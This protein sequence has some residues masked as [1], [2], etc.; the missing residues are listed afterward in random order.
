MPA[1][2]EARQLENKPTPT[3]FMACGE[4]Q[5]AGGNGVFSKI[6]R[7]RSPVAQKDDLALLTKRKH[8][9]IDDI[10]AVL[11]SL[12]GGSDF[13]SGGG[14]NFLAAIAQPMAVKPKA[15]APAA[16]MAVAGG[17]LAKVKRQRKNS[18]S[19]NRSMTGILYALCQSKVLSC[20]KEIDSEKLRALGFHRP[21][22]QFGILVQFGSRSAESKTQL[23]IAITAVLVVLDGVQREPLKWDTLQRHMLWKYQRRF[24]SDSLYLFEELGCS[25]RKSIEQYGR[26]LEQSLAPRT[27]D[28]ILQPAMA[29]LE[30][31]LAA[32]AASC[33]LPRTHIEPKAEPKAEPR[34]PVAMMMHV[35]PEPVHGAGAGAEDAADQMMF[36]Y[37]A[38]VVGADGMPLPAAS[39]LLFC[40][41]V[42]GCNYASPFRRYLSAHLRVHLGHKPYACSWPGC[43]YACAGSGHLA[44]HMRVHTKEKPYKCAWPGCNY[45][46]TQS[47]HLRGHIRVHQRP[48]S[49]DGTGQGGMDVSGS[50]GSAAL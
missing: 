45:A 34:P 22:D 32:A 35:E 16:V 4:G 2:A 21:E 8:S 44:R 47:G 15:P 31:S 26:S 40:C 14:S 5:T 6:P 10:A 36:D 11:T 18:L 24:Q 42:E 29:R 33:A 27:V 38:E 1:F 12:A 39:D 50:D 13:L 48:E 41:H 43:K 49:A 17:G 46:A 28:S 3:K 30:E 37:P 7:A 23:S 19:M 20:V 25:D 9:E